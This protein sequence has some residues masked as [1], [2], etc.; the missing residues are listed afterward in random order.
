MNNFWLYSSI[1]SGVVTFIS[2]ANYYTYSGSNLISSKTAKKL[3][4]QGKINTIIDVRTRVEYNIG[5][6][7]KS[8]N[9]PVNSITQET[10]KNISK[11]S[12]ILL[13]CNTGQRARFA[14]DKLNNL[15]FKNV[16]YIPGT[17]H[18]LI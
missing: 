1:L 15:G 12:N 2:L 6:F 17:Y 18:S 13:Y 8:I 9:I 7:P 16:V 5:H 10:T 3:L 4:D 14:S 11:D